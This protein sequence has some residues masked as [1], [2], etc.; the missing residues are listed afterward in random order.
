M[1]GSYRNKQTNNN[2]N[3]DLVIRENIGLETR[4][5][6]KILVRLLPGRDLE[7]VQS[8]DFSE[9]KFS[10]LEDGND[11]DVTRLSGECLPQRTFPVQIICFSCS[12]FLSLLLCSF[13][14]EPTDFGKLPS[15]SRRSPVVR[16]HALKTAALAPGRVNQPVYQERRVP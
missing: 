10:P 5:V 2:N 12:F 1:V 6:F 9:P 16:E 14:F 8:L 13:P 4:S 11:I 15:A 3:Y 7:H